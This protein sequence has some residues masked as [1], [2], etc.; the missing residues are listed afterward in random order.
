MIGNNELIT[1][2]FRRTKL[3]YIHTLKVCL[4]TTYFA[5]TE[6]LILKVL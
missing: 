6:K 1:T 2:R 3:E 4:D 5:E